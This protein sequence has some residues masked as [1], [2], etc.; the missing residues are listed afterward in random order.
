[1]DLALDRPATL[2]SLHVIFELAMM[3]VSLGGAVYLWLGWRHSAA[4][5]TV[6]R[7]TLAEREAERDLW[8]S[9]A[10][11]SLDGMGAAIARQFEQWGLTTTE[12]TV[13]LHL[14]K[15]HGHKQIAAMTG[16]SER[17]VRQHAVAVYEKAGLSG[18]AELAAFF[19]DDVL[20]PNIEP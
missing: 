19:L 12:R 16:R 18:R 20:L 10:R 15:G 5:L 3:S 2:W 17:T 14:L 9:R 11:Q 8:R 7:R 6:T 4:S 1:V 13:A